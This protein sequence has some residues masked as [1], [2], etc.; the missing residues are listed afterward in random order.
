MNSIHDLR[1]KVFVEPSTLANRPYIVELIRLQ[2]A[3]AKSMSED[4]LLQGEGNN[5]ASDISGILA[6]NSAD[7]GVEHDNWLNANDEPI[8]YEI[9]NVAAELDAEGN[10]KQNW[11]K[12]FL[13]SD[14]LHS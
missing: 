11:H 2:V 5:I 12:L 6:W 14:S 3:N 1:S 9:L 13:L 8:L 7:N 4:E 10:S